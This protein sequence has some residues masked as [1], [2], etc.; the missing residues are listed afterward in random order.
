L[1]WEHYLDAFSQAGHRFERVSI[2]RWQ[3]ALRTVGRENALFGV[4][5]FY[6]NDLAEDISDVSMICHDNAR[7]GV[8]AMGE[9]YPKKDPAL[10]RKGC[11]HLKAIG[12]I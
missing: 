4:L 10:L 8:D 6:L 7:Q 12:F 3:S 11:D 2:A 5:G 9:H 1:S